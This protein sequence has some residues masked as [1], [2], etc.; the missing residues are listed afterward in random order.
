MLEIVV[1]KV[2]MPKTLSYDAHLSVRFLVIRISRIVVFS[3][4]NR[5]DTEMLQFSPT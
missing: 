2:K 4:A 3:I 5:N 1:R